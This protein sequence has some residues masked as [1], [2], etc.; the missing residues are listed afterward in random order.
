EAHRR[1]ERRL[2]RVLRRTP[3]P[4]AREREAV[5]QREPRYPPHHRR[6]RP[7]R[8]RARERS[9][10]RSRVGNG[11]EGGN[12]F[13]RSNG[14]TENEQI[15]VCPPLLR[16]SVAPCESVISVTSASS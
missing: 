13:T 5:P 4:G 12:G 15:S 7:P 11:G 2:V 16:C 10:S 3:R 8:A 14:E 1:E 6:P 9:R